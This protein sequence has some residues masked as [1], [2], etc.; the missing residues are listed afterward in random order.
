VRKTLEAY[1]DK[2][3]PTEHARR[4]AEIRAA[5]YGEWEKKQAKVAS[6][7]AS[8]FR[9]ML[10]GRGG[11]SAAA[12]GAGKAEFNTW[13]DLERKRF[14]DAY[15]EDE[16]YWK[17]NGDAIRKQAKEDQERQLKDMKLDAW[18]WVPDCNPCLRTPL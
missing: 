18:R 13:Y 12:G 6:S 1:K 9:G 15:L 16:K 17:E 14:Q 10:G 3:I 5:E 7:L 4:Q 8:G 2:H 11:D